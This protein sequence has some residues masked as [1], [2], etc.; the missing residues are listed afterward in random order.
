M[1]DEVILNTLIQNTQDHRL[2]TREST[3][4]VVAAHQQI[5]LLSHVISMKL[6]IGFCESL[7]LCSL[8]NTI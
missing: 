1:L 2:A 8:T 4:R 6:N 5:L 3:A 7:T